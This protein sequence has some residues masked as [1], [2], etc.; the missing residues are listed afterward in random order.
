MNVLPWMSHTPNSTWSQ[1]YHSLVNSS[2]P[3]HIFE[4]VYIAMHLGVCTGFGCIILKLPILSNLKHCKDCESCPSQVIVRSVNV[5]DRS[6]LSYL[7][8]VFSL[9][10]S[11]PDMRGFARKVKSWSLKDLQIAYHV[12]QSYMSAYLIHQ[13]LNDASLSSRS[14]NDKSMYRAASAVKRYEIS[15]PFVNCF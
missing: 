2:S 5:S 12:P 8:C 4:V 13:P 1:T 7:S 9:S 6:L 14:V 11:Y 10:C 3:S 15:I